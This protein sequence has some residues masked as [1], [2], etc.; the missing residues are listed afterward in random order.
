LSGVSAV[1]A[2]EQHSLALLANGTVMA[3]GRNVRGQL[4]DGTSSGPQACGSDSCSTTPVVASTHGA[5]V[6]ISAGREHNLAFGPPASSGPLPQLGRCVKVTTKKGAYKYKNCVVPSAQANGAYEWQP[7]PGTSPK[8]LAKA[9]EVK[10]ET[11]G[12][13]T[14]TC[15]SAELDGDWTGSK[16][17]SVTVAFRGCKSLEKGCG[18]NPSKPNEILTEE[19]VEGELGFI[20]GGTK[21]RVGLDLKPKS[22]TTL[23]EFTCGGPPETT[24]PERWTVEGSVIGRINRVDAMKPTFQLLYKAAAGKQVPERFEGALKD[25]LIANRLTNNG[26]T[27]EQ[28]GLTLREEKPWIPGDY[29]EPLE[30]KAK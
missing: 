16:T 1:D 2:G 14:V 4:G 3:W 8:F 12:K 11:V 25:T 29:E 30:I 20:E 27:T 6:G 24:F 26:P 23:L 13:T 22:G 5:T 19:P 17:A 18:N 21:P 10:L 15:A 28:A 9:S 7:G